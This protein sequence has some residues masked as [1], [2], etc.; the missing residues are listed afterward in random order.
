MSDEDKPVEELSF[1]VKTSSDNLHAIT[2]PASATVLDLKNKLADAAYEDVPADRQRLIYSGR[3]LKNDEPLATYK[4][5]TGNTIHMVKSAASNAA[6]NPA[7][8]GAGTPT[9]APRA[10]AGVPTNM[11]AGTA[12]NPLANLTGARYAGQINLPSRD[13]FGVDGGVRSPPTPLILPRPEA[14]TNPVLDRWA[15]HLTKTK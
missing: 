11:A 1:K 10:A 6:Q 12:N 5:K 8:S 14:V 2:I 3:V 7:S 4:I 9:G 15:P 13:M